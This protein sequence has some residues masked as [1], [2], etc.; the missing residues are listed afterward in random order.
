MS[1]FLDSPVFTLF[2]CKVFAAQRQ[3]DA[4]LDAFCSKRYILAKHQCQTAFF[5]ITLNTA[6][7]HLFG[8]SAFLCTFSKKLF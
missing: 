3:L 1:C 6:E 5:N 2:L 7:Q 8:V 4:G